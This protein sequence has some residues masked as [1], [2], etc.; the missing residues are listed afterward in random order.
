MKFEQN[1]A[2]IHGQAQDN[3]PGSVELGQPVDIIPTATLVLAAGFLFLGY[4]QTYQ[5]YQLIGAYAWLMDAQRLALHSLFCISAF[6]LVNINRW[7]T[8]LCLTSAAGCLL[9]LGGAA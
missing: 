9:V 8:L 7:L 1:N 2:R 5:L 4:R 3:A 6:A